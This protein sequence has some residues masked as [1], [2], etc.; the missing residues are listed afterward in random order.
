MEIRLL[1][2]ADIEALL[3]HNVRL[4]SKTARGSDAVSDPHEELRTITPDDIATLDQSITKASTDLG[5]TRVWGLQDANEIRASLTLVHRPVMTSTLDRCLLII[6]LES[7]VRG[8]GWDTGLIEV[9]LAWARSQPTIEYVDVFVL[10]SDSSAHDFYQ[11]LGF[12]ENATVRDLFRI[13]G[14]SAD[15]VALSLKIKG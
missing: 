4:K 7:C 10:G 6:D 5:W 13:F 14:L 3:K 11:K 8:E 15:D 12:E 9:A 1:T 2:S